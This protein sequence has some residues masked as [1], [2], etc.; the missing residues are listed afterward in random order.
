MNQQNNG[1]GRRYLTYFPAQLQSPTLRNC[2]CKLGPARRHLQTN[3]FVF[4]HW[5]FNRPRHVA[6]VHKKLQTSLPPTHEAVLSLALLSAL[7]LLYKQSK[8]FLACSFLVILAQRVSANV[9]EFLQIPIIWDILRQ[10][11]RQHVWLETH[12]NFTTEEPT[13]SLHTIKSIKV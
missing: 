10:D 3:V 13:K 9:V 7:S 12:L 1:S 6:H 8:M 11:V 4:A 5:Q 2:G